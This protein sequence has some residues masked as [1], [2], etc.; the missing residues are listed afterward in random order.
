MIDLSI[1]IPTL[2]GNERRWRLEAVLNRLNTD[3]DLKTMEILVCFDRSKPNQSLNINFPFVQI[4]SSQ[5][6]LGRAGIRNLG[7]SM[8]KGSRLLF[9]DDDILI[10]E[11]C[12]QSHLSSDNSIMLTHATTEL[13]WLRFTATSAKIDEI[14]APNLRRKAEKCRSLDYN[15][16][17]PH[18]RKTALERDL[19]YANSIQNDRFMMA[20]GGCMSIDHL[21]FEKIGKFNENFGLRWGLEDIELGYRFVKNGGDIQRLW[22]QPIIHLDLVASDRSSRHTEHALNL[23]YFESIHGAQAGKRVRNYLHVPEIDVI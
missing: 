11:G 9:I 3:F 21:R 20:T 17:L 18:C 8:A 19:Q 7:A 4:I 12:F 15:I 1:I 10:P 13:P 6:Q 23:K 22:N 5:F 16:L 2:G 14:A